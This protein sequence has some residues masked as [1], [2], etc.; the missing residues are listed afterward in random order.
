[1]RICVYL[2]SSP[3]NNPL[4]REAAE[5]FGT[6]LARRG[7]GLVYGGGMVGLMGVIADA[8]CAAGGEVIGIIP[9]ALRAREHDHP[10]I[11]ELHVV[12]TM[13][14]RK[15]MMANLADGFVTL[16]GGIGTFEEMFEAWCWSQLG[17][18]NKPVGLLDVNGFYSGLRQF[19]DNVVEEGFLQPRHRSMLIVEKDPETM[20]DRIVNFVPPENEHWLGARDV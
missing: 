15:A 6:L 7:I 13:H 10:G 19:I 3:G 1:M 18:H 5:Q 16:P 4:Y 17:Y 8:V 20:I 2:G 12:Q 11:S 14:E 9:E